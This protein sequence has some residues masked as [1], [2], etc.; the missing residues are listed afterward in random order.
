MFLE[1]KPISLRTPSCLAELETSE[2]NHWSPCFGTPGTLRRWK[3]LRFEQVALSLCVAH[4][5]RK[6]TTRAD[7]C[8]T[9]ISYEL[10][11]LVRLRYL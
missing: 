10:R 9:A 4:Q 11:S 8:A 3:G 7:H 6:V 5:V 1:Y 2:L